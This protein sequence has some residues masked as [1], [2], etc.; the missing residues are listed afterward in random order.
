MLA[1]RLLG[2]CS[3]SL[4]VSCLPLMSTLIAEAHA[5]LWSSFM[6]CSEFSFLAHPEPMVSCLLGSSRL[7]PGLAPGELW[8]T[9]PLQS[10]FMQPSLVLSLGSELR[11]QSLSSQSPP[12]RWVSRQTSQASECWLAVILCAG[13]SLV[14]PLHPIAVL[15]S[16]ALKLPSRHPVSTSEG[17]S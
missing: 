5:R 4:S 7:F 6:W 15:S 3:S 1:H 17:H 8:Y 2:G 11:S 16:V 13:I 9:S 10:V 12:P 14:C